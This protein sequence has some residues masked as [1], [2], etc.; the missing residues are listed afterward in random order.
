MPI[1]I[2]PYLEAFKFL[3]DWSCSLLLIQVALLI[4]LILI[5]PSIDEN[6]NHKVSFF[7][8][9]SIVF[10]I[11]SILIGLNVIGTIPWSIQNINELVKNYGD[12]YQFPNFFG[13]KIWVI[14]FGQHINSALSLCC[15]LYIMK[16]KKKQS[17]DNRNV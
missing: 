12:I 7:L 8:F 4:T 14:A 3:K 13:I 17:N 16:P 2:I 6:K 1:E 11:F 9:L 10:S 5:K 15:L